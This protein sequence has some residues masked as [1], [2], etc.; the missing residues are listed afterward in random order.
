MGNRRQVNKI[1]KV[2]NQNTWRVELG[3]GQNLFDFQFWDEKTLDQLDQKRI[4]S[5]DTWTDEDTKLRE[6]LLDNPFKF[7]TRKEYQS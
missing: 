5:F 4:N 2:K 1:N 7:I 6:K 3:G